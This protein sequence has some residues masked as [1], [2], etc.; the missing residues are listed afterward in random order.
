MF[1]VN[2]LALRLTALMA[3]LATAVLVYAIAKRL[4]GPG[5]AL[6]ATAMTAVSPSLVYFANEAKPYGVEAC[7]SCLI[8][9]ATL[10]WMDEPASTGWWLALVVSGAVAVWLATP[11]PF[12]LAGVG[13]S[14]V[15][16]NGLPLRTRLGKAGQ[17]AG[18]WGASLGLAYASGVSVR[19]E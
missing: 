14:V 15:T 10:R 17:L 4:L 11:A 8:L 6:L 1:G 9:Y 3:G 19:R 16:A 13:L 7:V 12:V 2:E 18:C 5:V